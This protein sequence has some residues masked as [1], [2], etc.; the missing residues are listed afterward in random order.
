MIMSIRPQDGIDWMMCRC[1]GSRITSNRNR[2]VADARKKGATHI[3]MIDS[4]MDYPPNALHRLLS[5]DKEIVGATTCKRGDE[6]GVP[7]GQAM[8][9]ADTDA[10]DENL[11]VSS[12]S[13]L[14]HMNAFGCCFML[15]KMSV[16]DKIG[17]PAF[18]EPPLSEIEDAQGEDITFCRLAR[19]AGYDIWMDFDLSIELG[20]WGKKRYHIKPL[21]ENKS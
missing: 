1:E 16:F 3:L 5:H 14:I 18:Y 7:I 12:G 6:N 8:P 10:N 13:G 20:H 15:I 21:Q 2:L 11:K 19:E 17:L 4:D 9:T